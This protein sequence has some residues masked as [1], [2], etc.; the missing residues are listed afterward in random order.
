[1]VNILVMEAQRVRMACR[2]Q[3]PWA[4]LCHKDHAVQEVE[5]LSQKEAQF[6]ERSIQR[7]GGVV[8]KAVKC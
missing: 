7:G 6:L 4:S 1:M 2:A 8:R 5:V 3:A